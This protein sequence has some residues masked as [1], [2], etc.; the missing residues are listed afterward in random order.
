M[1]WLI[2]IE[3]KRVYTYRY[4]RYFKTHKGILWAIYADKSESLLDV[5]IVKSQESPGWR[6]SHQIFQRRD[7]SGQNPRAPRVE[8]EQEKIQQAFKVLCVKRWS[9]REGLRCWVIRS[10]LGW[11]CA[12]TLHQRNNIIWV[13]ALEFEMYWVWEVLSSW[14]YGSW[15]LK[16]GLSKLS[17][18]V[19]TGL[20]SCLQ[21]HQLVFVNMP[22]EVPRDKNT[23]FIRLNPPPYKYYLPR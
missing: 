22:S 9:V 6:L 18:Y 8:V 14:L 2:F 17:A 20:G 4:S 7:D 12:V 13:E 10:C 21:T 1:Y 23:F 15:T 19:A 16:R 5:W 11:Y 3:E